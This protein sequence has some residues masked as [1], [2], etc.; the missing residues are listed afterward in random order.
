MWVM[1]VAGSL[2]AGEYLLATGVVAFL[3]IVGRDVAQL[4]RALRQLVVL[5]LRCE[6]AAERDPLTGLLNRA[7][8]QRRIDGWG[9]ANPVSALFIDL[10]HF[11]A[12]NDR[13]GVRPAD[14]GPRR[15]RASSRWG[16]VVLTEPLE[17][18]VDPNVL[19]ARQIMALPTVAAPYSLLESRHD[20]QTRL[21]AVFVADDNNQ[22]E[23]LLRAD[24]ASGTGSVAL[25]DDQFEGIG[26][27]KL[28]VCYHTQRTAMVTSTLAVWGPEEPSRRL[29]S[30]E[31]T[32]AVC[33]RLQ[34][35]RGGRRLLD[36]TGT[37]LGHDPDTRHYVKYH[38]L[39][40]H[41]ANRFMPAQAPP[42]LAVATIPS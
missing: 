24:L 25:F 14:S 39:R 2:H 29:R 13:L 12:M 9:S 28:K 35:D 7:G 16:T 3:L 6:R 15:A 4:P 18:D 30:V 33:W 40:N 37:A 42:H 36:V 23:F 32:L 11:K 21:A 1:T 38:T 19:E 27:A 22:H 31:L 17:R 26:R 10:D 5:Q 34:F 8:I 20:R 41:E